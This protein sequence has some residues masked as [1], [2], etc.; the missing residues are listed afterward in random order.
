[1]G[2]SIETNLYLLCSLFNINQSKINNEYQG[3]TVEEIMEAE[4]K[5]GNTAA[6][7]FDKTI[8][9]DPAKLIQLFELQSPENKYVI[10]SNMND[11]DLEELLP[12]LDTDDLVNG[13]NYFNKEKILQMTEQLPQKDLVNFTMQMFSTEHLMQLIPEEQ[14][15][16]VL[17]S[18]QVSKGQ[19]AKYLMNL[20]PEIL[21][22]MIE[23]LTGQPAPG[24]ENIGMDGKPQYDKNQ[25]Y[26]MLTSLDDDKFK[27]ATL[28]IPPVN[29]QAF[30]SSL[31][32]DNPELLNNIDASAFVG[33]IN[34]KKDKDDILL[35]AD[36]LSKE[37]L[38][39]MNKE[40]PKDLTA[41]VLTQMD[42]EKF[43]EMLQSNFREILSKLSIA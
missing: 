2:I 16:K 17:M 25:L 32:N 26:G 22:Q 40:L 8:L 30:V 28:F 13:L 41:V 19:E 36:T 11:H 23:G 6:A 24:A 37:N 39:N 5:Q 12:M 29:K 33:A 31:I 7:S 1:M 9:N 43:A 34:Q 4:A 27:E 21:A 35:Y 10:L 14:L 20:K 15:N 18:S 3:M 38:V 42:T